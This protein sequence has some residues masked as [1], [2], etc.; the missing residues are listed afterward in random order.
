MSLSVVRHVGEG[1]V[2]RK[3]NDPT[4][5]LPTVD[6][7]YLLLQRQVHHRDGVA[8]FVGHV[9]EGAVGRKGDAEWTVC[10]HAMRFTTVLLP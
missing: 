8:D 1:A 2:G 10:L 5:M 4:D 3:G 9:G 6:G 7:R